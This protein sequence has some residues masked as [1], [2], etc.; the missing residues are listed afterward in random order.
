MCRRNAYL[1]AWFL[2]PFLSFGTT[3]V[4]IASAEEVLHMYGPLGPSPA[5][6]EAAIVFGDRHKVKL[7]V[8][9]GPTSQWLDRAKGDAHLIFS[10][11]EF[12]MGD[13]S[14]DKGL[15]IDEASVTPLYLRPSAILVRPGNPKNI[16]DFPDLLKPGVRVMV[17]TG[18]GQTGLWEDMAGKL[19]SIQT[20]RSFRKNIVFFAPDSGDA[21]KAWEEREDIDAWL[22]WSIWYMPVRDHAEHI[23]VS[24]D[25]RVYRQCSIAL[26]QRGK[27]DP[28]ARQFIEFL[29]S[30][31]A[32]DI[33]KTWGWTTP[34]HDAGP[35]T[36]QQAICVVCRVKDDEWEGNVG[37][38]L[39][40]LKRLVDDYKFMGVAPDE[41]HISAVFHGPAAYWLLRD[42]SYAAFTKRE[43][44]NPNKSII[45]E[46]TKSGV[47]IELCGQTLRR[48]G[49][50]RG[51]VLPEVKV[52]VGAYP[53]II[54]LELQGY[55]YLRF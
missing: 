50:N 8:T 36:V 22:T 6:K 31:E 41:V 4:P 23:Q 5:F 44:P 32:A 37:M 43:G 33:F 9:A 19:G 12:M 51:D 28:L 54:D 2:T 35:I 11:A 55:A 18:S 39:A 38:G 27:A 40:C 13:F 3:L 53:R 14:R 34:P 42:E 45:Q 15:Q 16:R 20:L 24:K 52:V 29:M 17:V 10:S 30:P 47:S 21:K 1:L 48:N 49:W 25:Y 26:T 46:L 7:D